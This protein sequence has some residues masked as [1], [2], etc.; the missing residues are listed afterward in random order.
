MV[1]FC[2]IGGGVCVIVD[3]FREGVIACAESGDLLTTIRTRACHT[4]PLNGIET[5]LWWRHYLHTT[6]L[7]E[8]DCTQILVPVW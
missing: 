7:A 5:T 6:V 4:R 3:V 8:T 2:W 1:G